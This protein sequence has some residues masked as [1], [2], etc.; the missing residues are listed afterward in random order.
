MVAKT[1]TDYLASLTSLNSLTPGS[2][3]WVAPHTETTS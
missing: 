3:R 2:F 1:A